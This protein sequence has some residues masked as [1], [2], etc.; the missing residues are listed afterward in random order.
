[1]E[2]NNAREFFVPLRSVNELLARVKKIEKQAIKNNLEIPTFTQT[3]VIEMRKTPYLDGV[4]D[5]FE[6]KVMSEPYVKF[7][8][9][10]ETPVLKGYSLIAKIEHNVSEGGFKN[11]VFPNPYGKT[12]ELLNSDK[13]LTETANCKPNCD[14]CKTNR[15]RNTTYLFHNPDGGLDGKKIVQVG[16]TCVESFMGD[17]SLEWLALSQKILDLRQ[18]AEEE[19]L[20][21]NNNQPALEGYIPTDTFIKAASI[22]VGKFGFEARG[23]SVRKIHKTVNG[24]PHLDDTDYYIGTVNQKTLDIMVSNAKEKSI[25]AEIPL[26]TNEGYV[27]SVK[28]GPEGIIA[29]RTLNEKEKLMFDTL[30]STINIPEK[31]LIFTQSD[32]GIRIFHPES[33]SYKMELS[34]LEEKQ[35]YDETVNKFVKVRLPEIRDAGEVP[36]DFN[37]DVRLMLLDDGIVPLKKTGFCGWLTSKI[38]TLN[39]KFKRE[40]LGNKGETVNVKAKVVSMD[41]DI[42]EVQISRY[43]SV[44]NEITHVNFVTD[45][46]HQVYWKATKPISQLETVLKIGDTYEFK[47]KISGTYETGGEMKT[48]IGGM[49]KF[50]P[51][52]DGTEPEQKSR[53]KMK[54]S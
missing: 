49:R 51:V 28:L 18:E 8:I 20:K 31:E 43:G 14:H 36:S 37:L 27:V 24:S 42:S 21:F 26:L 11:T 39:P 19:L 16:S 7:I 4:K 15:M 10:G 40:Y 46:G 23:E 53:S 2:P 54:P 30:G 32:R 3:D 22:V 5:D 12:A 1:M 25:E 34:K 6:T 48:R 45:E 41:G 17:K 9:K 52:I 13:L 44:M 47:G 50:T 33:M 38:N 29:I 35:L